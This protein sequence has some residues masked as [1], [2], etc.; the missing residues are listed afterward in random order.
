M[1][2]S[3]P[4]DSDHPDDGQAPDLVA[5]PRLMPL[6][7][8]V[9]TELRAELLAR[10]QRRFDD[11]HQALAADIDLEVL[12][13]RILEHERFGDMLH[14]AVNAALRTHDTI[15]IQLLAKAVGSGVLAEDE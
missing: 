1:K 5:L 13:Q 12:A 14:D 10:E 15:K 3:S 2:D 7:G 8:P 9:A 6:R 11:F 4:V